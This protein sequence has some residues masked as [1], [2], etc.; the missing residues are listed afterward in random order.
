M[1]RKLPY[2]GPKKAYIYSETDLN[3]HREVECGRASLTS[4]KARDASGGPFQLPAIAILR[5]YN[6]YPSPGSFPWFLLTV[7]HLLSVY[8]LSLTNYI[9]APGGCLQACDARLKCGHVCP[10]KVSLIYSGVSS[11]LPLTQF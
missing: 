1:R 2:P 11:V 9:V 5:R 6:V 10:Y 8:I 4:S 7:C 3:F